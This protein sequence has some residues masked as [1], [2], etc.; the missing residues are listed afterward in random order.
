MRWPW[1]Y[2]FAK[3]AATDEEAPATDSAERG[4]GDQPGAQNSPKA[5]SSYVRRADR[6]G[7]RAT[8]RTGIRRDLHRRARAEGGLLRRRL[9]RAV[10]QQGRAVRRDGAA[11]RTQPPQGAPTPVRGD[12]RRDAAA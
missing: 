4:A 2:F 9:L 1:R 8:R 10:P 11:T 3:V 6:Y 5:W 12:E 7:V